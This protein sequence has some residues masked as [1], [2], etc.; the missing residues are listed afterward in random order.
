MCKITGILL[1]PTRSKI[2]WHL[3]SCTN[4]SLPYSTSEWPNLNAVQCRKASDR[5]NFQIFTYF[6]ET[7]KKVIPQF[8]N[9]AVSLP[10]EG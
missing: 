6:Q 1:Y 5:H 3:F 10:F 4:T 9:K 7:V 2:L 8:L